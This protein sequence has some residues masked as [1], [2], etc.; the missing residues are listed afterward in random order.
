[1][2]GA[3]AVT[4]RAIII[5]I[6]ISLSLAGCLGDG[7][8]GDDDTDPD[9]GDDGDGGT[10]GTGGDNETEERET[11]P[12]TVT[13]EGAYAG[14]A[15]EAGGASYDKGT[16]TVPANSTV[17]LT[18]VNSDQEGNPMGSHDIAV[19]GFESAGADSDTIGPGAEITITFDVDGP[20]ET[21]FYCTITGHRDNGMEGTFIVE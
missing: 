12:I 20:T 4:M 10:G 1:M 8:S 6:L 2:P 3:V 15:T 7:D 21:A 16:L 13:W 11:V 18:F 17:E 19:E 5:A 14:P 9:T